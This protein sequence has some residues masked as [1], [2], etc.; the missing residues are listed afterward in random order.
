MGS[1]ISGGVSSLDFQGLK[2]SGGARKG[3][4]MKITVYRAWQSAKIIL[5]SNNHQEGE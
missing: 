1:L 3:A 5:T 2:S 4:V